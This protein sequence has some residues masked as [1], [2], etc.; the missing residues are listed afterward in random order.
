MMSSPPLTPTPSA[1]V[2]ASKRLS[3]NVSIG[4]RPLHLLDGNV[5]SPTPGPV[6]APLAPTSFRHSAPELPSTPSSSKSPRPNSRRQSSI[7]YRSNTNDLSLSTRSPLG[8]A[9]YGLTRS[10][11]V[12]PKSN[13][14][15]TPPRDR[16]SAGFEANATQERPPLTLA[17]KHSELL[18]FIAQ[19]EAKCL[20][21][22]SQLAIHEDELLQLKRKWERIVN[23]GFLDG[24][25]SQTP[26]G[27]GS[28]AMLEGIR[29]GV[30]GVSRFIA[31]G[32]SIGELSPAPTGSP[33]Q[34]SIP[35]PRPLRP[36]HSNSQSNSSM[37]TYTT[38]STRFSQSSASSVGEEP[39]T[40]QEKTED[41]GEDLA[42]VLMVH[43]TGAT[44][45]MSPNPAFV[46]RQQRGVRTNTP[47]QSTRSSFETERDTFLTSSKMH[48]RRSRDAHSFEYTLSPGEYASSSSPSV[49]PPPSKATE[50]EKSEAARLKRASLNGTGFPPVSSIPGLASLTVGAASP[51]VASWV[52]SV[53]KKWEELQRGSTFSK[54]QKRASILLAD[55][56][57]SIVSA[58]SSPP[59]TATFKSPSPALSS[60]FSPSPASPLSAST[61]STSLLD[62]DDFSMPIS[63]I[64]TPD[65]TS[66]L[67]PKP[68]PQP[69]PILQHPTSTTTISASTA[70][71]TIASAKSKPKDDE[72]EWNW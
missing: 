27:Q 35:A 29:E 63:S 25:S 28:G 48:R 47:S 6:T 55:V 4:P 50:T 5:P 36:T 8:S 58:L 51:P 70:S 7:S 23:R 46:Q 41:E 52:G 38:K 68:R 64:M 56:S 22:R 42:Q 2:T 67:K 13:N 1:P 15:N 11:S 69:D 32:L 21:L 26:N 61:T 57:Q 43:D 14:R 24:T 9:G 54:N 45:T 10:Q 65:T 31:A 40:P 60:Y 59:S 53:G 39:I 34:Y 16:R 33:S 20:E 3:L 17:E 72:D 71:K 44:P 37:S 12:G 66:M 30:Q 49:S 18:H 62:D 19:K